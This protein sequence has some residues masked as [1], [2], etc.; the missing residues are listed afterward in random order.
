[1][2]SSDETSIGISKCSLDRI[3]SPAMKRW[4]SALGAVVILLGGLLGTLSATRELVS[5]PITGVGSVL[6]VAVFVTLTVL[7][8]KRALALRDVSG[9]IYFPTRI[10]SRVSAAL[11][12]LLVI[13]WLPRIIGAFEDDRRLIDSSVRILKAEPAAGTYLSR[14]ELSKGVHV[15]VEVEFDMPYYEVTS[16]SLLPVISF[17]QLH[18]R[19]T[20]GRES[21][22]GIEARSLSS[23]RGIER[24]S[25]LLDSTLTHGQDII[26]RVGLFHRDSRGRSVSGSKGRV[27]YRLRLIADSAQ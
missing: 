27:E 21:W 14:A 23:N 19:E 12:A 8:R 20:G 6:I 11:S 13:L 5:W 17:S 15:A 7:T 16:D 9:T 26:L 3:A 25:G 10:P 2:N 4:I 22:R 24:L 18:E 1:L